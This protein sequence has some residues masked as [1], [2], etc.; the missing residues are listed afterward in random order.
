[1]TVKKDVEKWLQAQNGKGVRKFYGK[2]QLG[3]RRRKKG[4]MKS[5]FGLEREILA[6]SE[7]KI[8]GGGGGSCITGGRANQNTEGGREGRDGIQREE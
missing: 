4:T 1:V 2:P 7:K 6:R 5:V 8:L 3:K